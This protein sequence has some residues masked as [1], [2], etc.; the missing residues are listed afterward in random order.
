MLRTHRVVAVFLA[1]T[2]AGV[3]TA[4]DAPANY[5]EP[6]LYLIVSAGIAGLRD[7][8]F[9]TARL[10]ATESRTLSEKVSS[11][12]VAG[13]R[14]G[15]RWKNWAIELDGEVFLLRGLSGLGRG[16]V[17]CAS[18]SRETEEEQDRQQESLACPHRQ[19]PPGHVSSWSRGMTRP[20][21]RRVSSSR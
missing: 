21:L 7:D 9:V 2:I 12:L 18:L 6:G 15:H 14:F 4:E 5:A 11:E 8:V 19:S 17:G 3:S 16:R 10:D 13:A 20:P 1:L